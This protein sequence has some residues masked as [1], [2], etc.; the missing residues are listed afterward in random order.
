MNHPKFHYKPGVTFSYH[1]SV[2]VSSLFEGTGKNASTF[3]IESNVTVEL[4]S[5]CDGVLAVDEAEL[6]EES[7]E[8]GR[9]HRNDKAL[10]ER[11]RLF[12]EALQ[13]HTLRFSY[14]DGLIAEICP[15]AEELN[16]VLNFKR[17]LLSMLQNSM[18]RFD[19]DHESVEE[20]V[21]GRCRTKYK[22]L[23]AKETSLLVEKSK[24]LDSCE[25]R[26]R[27]DSVIQSTPYKFRPVSANF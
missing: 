25:S 26:S 5:S 13:E 23:G 12:S 8:E 9:G 2:N 10:E 14:H 21:H 7:D 11:R 16:W 22:V 24:D 6:T 17:G 1:Y 4:L 19:L 18:R 15:K 20:D 3:R 27:I